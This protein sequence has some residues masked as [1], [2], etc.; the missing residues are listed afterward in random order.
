VVSHHPHVD[1][2]ENVGRGEGCAHELL[3]TGF[4]SLASEQT[5]QHRGRGA[6]E[7]RLF[8][9]LAESQCLFANTYGLRPTPGPPEG[10]RKGVADVGETVRRSTSSTGVGHGAAELLCAVMLLGPQ[11]G[12]STDGEIDGVTASQVFS[13]LEPLGKDPVGDE[14]RT[15]VTATGQNTGCR[16]DSQDL[17]LVSAGGPHYPISALAHLKGTRGIAAGAKNHRREGE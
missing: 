16:Q 13:P 3:A 10:F 1:V 15:L 6:D 2:P 5:G 17:Q 7:E 8:D 12:L 4:V 14:R 9:L 11:E